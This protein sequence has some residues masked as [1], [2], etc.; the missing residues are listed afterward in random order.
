M[1]HT[2]SFMHWCKSTTNPDVNCL[3]AIILTQI[4]T[5]QITNLKVY[6]PP[7]QGVV[8]HPWWKRVQDSK[9]HLGQNVCSTVKGNELL[10]ISFNIGTR[11]CRLIRLLILSG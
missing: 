11:V 6:F 3:I 4:S 5:S 8:I 10:Q 9:Q 2:C 7:L 1:H